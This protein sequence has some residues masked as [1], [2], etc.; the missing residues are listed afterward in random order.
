MLSAT[1]QAVLVALGLLAIGATLRVKLRWLRVLYI[2]AAVVAGGL[3]FAGVQIITRNASHFPMLVDSTTQIAAAWNTWPGLLI[4]VVFTALLLERSQEGGLA[5]ALRRG[6]RSAIVAWIIILG[7]LA[8]GVLVFMLAV[9]PRDPHVPETFSQLLE[10]SWAGGHGS[11]AGMG[12]LY[13][14]QGF[15]EGRDLAFFS[16]TIGLIYGVI[17]GLV[18]VNLAIRKRW[19][20]SD[21]HA[22]GK[23]D[24]AS[25]S[26]SNKPIA[27]A[28]IRGEVMEPIVV[29]LIILAAA[30]VVGLL[31]QRAFVSI[32]MLAL[33]INHSD[34]AHAAVDAASNVPL[35]L[36]T[37]LGGWIVRRGMELLKLGALIDTASI[38]RLVGVSMEFL[39]VA[40]IATMRIEALS[41]FGWPLFL[42]VALAA[43]WAAFCLLVL[44]R[45]LLPKAY[46][47]ELGLLNYGF[48]TANTPQ[49]MMLLR[50]IDPDLRSNAAADYAVAAP[51]S[52]PFIGGGIVTFLVLP[53]MLQRFPP[54]VMLAIFVAGIAIL[55]V[56]GLRLSRER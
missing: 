25:T 50:M 31:L 47:F 4:A 33:H 3:G 10:I 44:S 35:F 23:V 19:T 49:G 43:I 52:A 5:D 55:F 39:I 27:F 17:S 9:H 42:L 14:K 6:V 56:A 34:T 36:F 1:L 8:I 20:M 41:R 46:W 29:Q 2:P 15:P 32:A 54:I 37:L 21:P 53:I 11:A 16:A 48:S 22:A 51:L 18:L 26:R 40:G 38:Q 7:Q 12:T 24:D 30:F 13:A 45:M 28:T